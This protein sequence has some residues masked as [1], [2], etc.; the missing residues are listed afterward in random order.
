MNFQAGQQMIN[1]SDMFYRP[2]KILFISIIIIL[3]VLLLS[4]LLWSFKVKRPME[5]LVMNKA[6]QSVSR[7]EHKAAFWILNYNR[8]VRKS[9][10]SYNHRKDYYGFFPIKPYRYKEYDV[11]N[12]RFN[13]ID[14]LADHYDM[15]WFIDTYGLSFGEWYGDVADETYSRML[16]GGLNQEDYFY[17]REMLLRNKP[18]IAEFNFFASPTSDLL[19]TKTEE[20]A[21]IY[22]SGWTGTY[23][24]NMDYNENSDLPSR[25]I[26]LYKEQNQGSWP[27]SRSGIILL[28]HENR[29]LVLENET[30]I[31]IELPLI[32]TAA[33][34]AARY[35]VSP[36]IHFPCR[37]DIC[38]TADT[39]NVISYYELYPTAEGDSILR[40]NNIPS[41]FPAV[42]GN[43]DNGP[44]YY[45]AGSFSDYDIAMF[46]S[47]FTGSRSFDFMLLRDRVETR[48]KF[49]SEFYY[50]FISTIITD[51]QETLPVYD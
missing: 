17:I 26:N 25:I 44:F 30:H 28:N 24:D 14:S 19:R 6:V 40:K 8:F 1:Y 20:L 43:F 11:R 45:L 41:R 36:V 23:Y 18:V 33:D 4:F 47:R 39:S 5:I 9:G 12:I 21:G 15:A 37:F 16:Y 51:Y 34:K 7:H 3:A 32:T 46:T 42:I 2:A 10:K 22:W 49:F 50:P 13:D 29:V 35:G 38:Y 27:Y 31:E 48:G